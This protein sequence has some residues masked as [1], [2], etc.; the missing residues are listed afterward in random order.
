ME[1]LDRTVVSDNVACIVAL[2]QEAYDA[3]SAHDP[4]TLYAI[5]P[6]VANDT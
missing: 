4:L 1:K 5:R 2:T 3:M 6:E